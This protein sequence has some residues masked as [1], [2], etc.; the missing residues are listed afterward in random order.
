MVVCQASRRQLYWSH[1]QPQ[2]SRVMHADQSSCNDRKQALCM[3]L[4]KCTTPMA[5][6][7]SLLSHQGIPAPQP[8]VDV[9]KRFHIAYLPVETCTAWRPKSCMAQPTVLQEGLFIGA[10]VTQASLIDYLLDAS[11]AASKKHRHETNG[12]N[13]HV[14]GPQ[15]GMP[16]V[17]TALAHH[18]QR[19]AGNPVSLVLHSF[20]TSAA[21]P[22]AC[23]TV[24][25]ARPH[26]AGIASGCTPPT[27]SIFFPSAMH[28]QRRGLPHL[29]GFC[30]GLVLQVRLKHKAPQ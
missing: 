27:H 10:A 17:Y 8:R 13:G 20:V 1:V 24:F 3:H 14:V 25:A 6:T 30:I 18:L 29:W 2:V 21:D 28:G 16:G 23:V 22:A 12:G 4:L 26:L 15:G 19:I 11:S 9:V 5:A 7:T